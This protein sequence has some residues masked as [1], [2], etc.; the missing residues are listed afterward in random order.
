MMNP[1]KLPSSA[2]AT[3]SSFL[4][5]ESSSLI[6][7]VCPFI[8]CLLCMHCN[9]L[10]LYFF[11]Q[12]ISTLSMYFVHICLG[13]TGKSV[14]YKSYPLMYNKAFSIKTEGHLEGSKAEVYTDDDDIEQELAKGEKDNIWAIHNI[15]SEKMLNERQA[16]IGE[17]EVEI[18][19]SAE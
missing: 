6:R 3:C 14:E 19:L 2:V 16:E 12:E 4:P 9:L 7:K 5:K 11:Y 15:L 17:V 8:I 13:I 18:D 10:V 1:L